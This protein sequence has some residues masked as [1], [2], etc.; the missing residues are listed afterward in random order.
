MLDENVAVIVHA[1]E[2]TDFHLNFNCQVS[3]EPPP[4]YTNSLIFYIFKFEYPSHLLPQGT[5]YDM[6]ASVQFFFR[7]WQSKTENGKNAQKCAEKL[8]IFFTLF[9]R[10]I[11]KCTTITHM[12]GLQYDLLSF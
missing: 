5:F 11:L 9:G 7:K 8:W 10:A 3:T 2:T 12:K 6:K 4:F 1:W